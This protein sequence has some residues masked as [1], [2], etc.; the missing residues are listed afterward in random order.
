MFPFRPCIF[1]LYS[2]LDMDD[3]EIETQEEVIHYRL[4]PPEAELC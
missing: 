3:A 2:V 1:L 4:A